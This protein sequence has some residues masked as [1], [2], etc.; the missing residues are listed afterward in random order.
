VAQPGPLKFHYEQGDFAKVALLSYISGMTDYLVYNIEPASPSM[1]RSLDRHCVDRVPDGAS[2]I[3]PDRS[4]L[5]RIIVGNAAG[6]LASLDDLY[7]SGVQ[8]P[9]QQSE[10]PYLR[11]VVSASP[12]YF[13]PDDPEAVGTWDD[14]RLSAW[15]DATMSQLKAEHGDDLVY[16]EL[17]LDED[18][19]HIHAVLAPTYAKKPRKPGRKKRNETDEEFE[20]RKAAALDDAG[21]R[22]VGRA[23]HPELSKKGSFQRLRERMAVAVDHL[24]IEYGEDRSVDAPPG[25]ST[26][27]W[28]KDQAAQLRKDRALLAAEREKLEDVRDD[29]DLE[30]AGIAIERKAIIDAAH[31]SAGRIKADAEARAL[32]M[33]SGGRQAAKALTD[34]AR[35]DAKAIMDEATALRA[36]VTEDAMR[37][38]GELNQERQHLSKITKMIRAVVVKIGRRFGLDLETK[39]LVRDVMKIEQALSAPAEEP[40]KEPDRDD[41]PGF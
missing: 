11:I 22:T 7:A 20:A 14:G 16:A 4:S 38:G 5:N 1:I 32:Q 35:A 27:Q 41:G 13:R 12:S 40:A 17:H 10:S 33:V 30:R 3:D 25:I 36:E 39:D 28:V 6:V 8:K 31:I 15:V 26:R 2:A 21:I 24:G 19:P 37:V 9:A 34:E 23:S 29:L 18:T